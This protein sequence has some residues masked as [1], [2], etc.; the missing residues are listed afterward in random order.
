MSNSAANSV[1]MEAGDGKPLPA[2]TILLNSRTVVERKDFVSTGILIHLEGDMLEIEMGESK[3]YELGDSVRIAIYSPIG[4][5]M[6]QSTVIA[7]DDETLIVINPPENRRK[8]AEKREHP[9]VDIERPGHVHAIETAGDA[10]GSS[11]QTIP[12]TVNNMSVSG[13]GFTI[14]GE[15]SIPEKAKVGLTV[16]LEKP[17]V[18]EVEIVRRDSAANG[19]YY[20]ARFVELSKDSLNTLRGFVL[21][22]QVE[23][24][25]SR[26][27]TETKKRTFK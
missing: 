10:G 16:Q 20:G 11:E 25:A 3:R 22:A 12:F 13:I 18:C 21:R 19:V 1:R 24:H 27:K 23:S 17:L 15:W 26:K 9:R 4:L 7:K 8:F 14:E 5:C 6:F 2:A